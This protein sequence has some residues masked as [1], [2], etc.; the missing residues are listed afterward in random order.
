MN[1][2]KSTITLLACCCIVL[3]IIPSAAADFVGVTT[4][5][6]DDPDTEFLCT[7]GNGDFVPGPLTVCNVF[8]VFD[9]PDDRLLVETDSPYLSPDPKRGQRPNTP[10]LVRYTVQ[11]LAEVR[12][13]TSEA[14]AK[15]TY[16]NARQLFGL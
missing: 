14:L 15:M 16:E 10:A 13:T 1:E 12:G 5:T 2:A 4:V 9:D 11:C 6:R 7:H 3:T 8:A